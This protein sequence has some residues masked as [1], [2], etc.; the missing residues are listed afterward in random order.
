VAGVIGPMATKVRSGVNK[1]RGSVG[2]VASALA[3][4]VAVHA[5]A[6]VLGFRKDWETKCLTKFHR[7]RSLPCLHST[8][9][10][11][12]PSNQNSINPCTSE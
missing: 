8:L 3:A 9:T 4:P 5:G 10:I 6:E 12:C 2:A 7:E 1:H 11:S